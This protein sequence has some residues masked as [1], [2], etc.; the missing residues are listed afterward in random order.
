MT[1]SRADRRFC[2]TAAVV[3]AAATALFAAAPLSAQSR[4]PVSLVPPQGADDS[5][6]PAPP[7][8]D[9]QPAPADIVRPLPGS[10]GTGVRIRGLGD[11]DTEAVGLSEGRVGG[12]NADMWRG[13]SRALAERLLSSMPE[14]MASAA[15][16]T[17]ARDLLL[18]A[19]EPPG[20]GRGDVSLVE[21]RVRNLI[22]LGAAEDAERLMSAVSARQLPANLV[23]PAAQ[24]R[25]LKADF[26]GAC[27]AVETL[28]GALVSEFGQKA[29]IFCQLLAQKF[30]EAV[31][32]LELL[33]EQNLAQDALFFEL[34]NAIVSGA[35]PTAE[36]L[37]A[38]GHASALNLAMVRL[39]GAAVPDWF[40]DADSPSLLK[41]LAQTSEAAR[42]VRLQAA[43][44][45]GRWGALSPVELADIYRSTGMTA[46]E[47]TAA[48]LEPESVSDAMR[49]AAIYFAAERQSI[50][51]ARAEVLRE[52]WR[53]AAA[54]GDR[55]LAARVTAPQLRRVD[56]A[57]AF[58]WFAGDALAASL[59]AGDVGQ[60][61]DWFEVAVNRGDVDEDAA[62]AATALWPALRMAA[63]A[64]PS[65]A[66]NAPR[67]RVFD[68]A[69]QRNVAASSG[70]IS[71]Q[72]AR[73]ERVQWNERRL[74]E[75]IGLQEQNGPDGRAAIALHLALFD[76]LGERVSDASWVRAEGAAPV[77]AALPPLDVWSGLQRAS[78]AGRVAETALYALRAVG[79][80]ETAQLHP[81]ALHAIVTA[82]RRVG[83]GDSARAF[84]LEA[85][86]A[87]AP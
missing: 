29:L 17:L 24:A 21:L 51:V 20:S 45:A 60:A 65:A 36:Q 39:A 52:G 70:V 47:V 34:S 35:P 25:L 33:R 69:G 77:D 14:R 6:T 23:E 71:R 54:Q 53:L 58:S 49:L 44:R 15:A 66:P 78:G 22:A 7:R 27:Q 75:W 11:V 80:N 13:T 41:A 8:P 3:I 73:D 31:L 28:D 84:A 2:L 9:A 86:L 74:A 79:P 30:S 62:A 81:V 4:A 61:I 40:A 64:A 48:L 59:A 85:A 42:E 56:P 19:A 26:A 67:A 82:L 43:L 5:R 87:A 37:A 16:Q 32:G 83:L 57:P 38:P 68:Q 55:R 46:D 12:L 18:V 63:G 50:G 1:G 76:A 10:S 72:T